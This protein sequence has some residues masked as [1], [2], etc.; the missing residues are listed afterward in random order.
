LLPFPGNLGA[1]LHQKSGLE[2]L[3]KNGPTASAREEAS[4]SFE[5]QLAKALDLMLEEDTI[6]QVGSSA[7]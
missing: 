1:Q 7:S 5:Q 2:V 4:V 3:Q 6:S